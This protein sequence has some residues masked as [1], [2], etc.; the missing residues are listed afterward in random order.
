MDERFGVLDIA[1]RA[2]R[3]PLV[4]HDDVQ[5]ASVLSFRA[6]IGTALH[7]G[8]ANVLVLRDGVVFIDQTLAILADAVGDLAG[9]PW[10]LLCLGGGDG[11]DVR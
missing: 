7:R 6:A 3:V 11:S 1:W 5:R 2:E 4:D 9:R 8:Y 10:D